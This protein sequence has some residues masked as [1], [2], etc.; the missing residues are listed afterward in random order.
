M[1]NTSGFDET[2]NAAQKLLADRLAVIETHKRNTLAEDEARTALVER[3]RE[4]AQSWAAALAAGWSAAE[5]RQIGFKEPAVRAPGRPRKAG[6]TRTSSSRQRREEGTTT[7][8]VPSQTS[9]SAGSE[10]AE[11]SQV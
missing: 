9:T 10:S 2:L 1:T 8:G 4:T 3:E 6:S 5:M 7:A 11:R